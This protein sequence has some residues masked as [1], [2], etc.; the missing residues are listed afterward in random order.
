ML[1]EAQ[2]A[3]LG[4]CL[5]VCAI[6]EHGISLSNRRAQLYSRLK[7]VQAFGSRGVLK[8]MGCIKLYLFLITPKTLLLRL[9][10][11]KAIK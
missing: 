10:T 1:E 6:T 8:V 7:V 5:T 9:K 3:V 4:E 11:R 2:G